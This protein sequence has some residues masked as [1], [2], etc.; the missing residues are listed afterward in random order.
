MAYE[1]R[2]NSGS[3]FRNDRATSDRHPTHKGKA[4]IGGVDYWVSAWVKEAGQNSK[5]PGARFFSLAF[6]PKE[7]QGDIP[8]GSEGAQEPRGGR[9]AT[10][11]AS[12]HPQASRTPP[13][14]RQAPRYDEAPIDDE[15]DIPF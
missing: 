1:P 3:L 13:A 9:G 7:Q 11:Q 8:F 10:A 2:D 5:N 6:E 4:T 15:D 14:A 12:G